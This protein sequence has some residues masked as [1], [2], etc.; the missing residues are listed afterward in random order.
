MAFESCYMAACYSE[1]RNLRLNSLAWICSILAYANDS[2]DSPKLFNP[3]WPQYSVFN[4]Y[5]VCQR[6]YLL[7]TRQRQWDAAV[8][9]LTDPHA[10]KANAPAK[11][12]DL[13]H[14]FMNITERVSKCVSVC[15]K[16]SI[17]KVNCY[18]FSITSADLLHSKTMKW[19]K[20]RQT[21]KVVLVE[22]QRRT[23]SHKG[24]G[25]RLGYCR[26]T[27]QTEFPSL[28]KPNVTDRGRWNRKGV[29]K[30]Q[31]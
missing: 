27:F 24:W 1:E 7:G 20:P 23:K 30:R 29:R 28:M 8:M 4:G 2:K 13:F 3:L 25:S 5:S 12:G 6:N 31:A 21:K 22:G 16:C 18:Y 26:L 11:S 9:I 10:V 14:G 15:E 19:M 17:N